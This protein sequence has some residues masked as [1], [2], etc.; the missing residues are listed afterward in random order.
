MSV[1]SE[2]NN[3]EE[4]PLTRDLSVL[5]IYDKRHSIP[6]NRDLSRAIS[7]SR[8]A[9]KVRG[10]LSVFAEKLRPC[11][12]H[13]KVM[14][15]VSSAMLRDASTFGR[16][17]T[18][19]Y[20]IQRERLE[21]PATTWS[22][23][24]RSPD[25]LSVDKNNYVQFDQIAIPEQQLHN[26]I[27]SRRL[28]IAFFK[29]HTRQQ[30]ELISYITFSIDQLLSIVTDR[31]EAAI[32]MEGQYGDED[33]LGNVIVQRVER[34]VNS[35]VKDESEAP[36]QTFVQLRADHFL[37]SKFVSSLNDGPKHGRRLRQL[38]AFITLH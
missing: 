18:Q 5:T 10:T 34:W 19:F 29:R 11:A 28:R 1:V 9:K 36:C 6:R 15:A 2:C 16:R 21:G 4:E 38:P 31:T 24:F 30:H 7:S 3:G 20:E 35:N 33:G 37:H 27:E 25:G 23:V 26:M 22:C 32:K 8:A 12:Q 17:V 14:F 13:K